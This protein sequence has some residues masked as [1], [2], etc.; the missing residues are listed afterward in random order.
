MQSVEPTPSSSVDGSRLGIGILFTVLGGV[1]W[2][3]SGACAQFLFSRYG[4]DPR[5]VVCVRLA[6]ACLVFLAVSAATDRARLAAAARSPKAMA[7]IA[8]YSLGGLTLCMVCYLNAIDASNAGTATV[9]QALNL[10]IIL[11]VTCV[12]LRR[13]PTPKEA[14]GVALA[15]AGTFLLATHGHPGTLAITPAA[16]GWG[17]AT[18]VAA[19]LY[20]LLPVR[21]LNEFGSAV[22]TGLAMLVGAVA[23]WA[24]FRPWELTPALDAAG[25]LAV[26]CIVLIGTVAAYFLFLTGVKKVGSM[27]A[28][29]FGSTEPITAGILSAVWLGTQFSPADLA[30]MGLIVAMMVL[31]A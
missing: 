30:G 23:S 1:C 26:A 15:L 20:T 29:L 17:L 4:V 28:G 10:L 22:T 19:A 24:V 13:R 2:G 3:F 14:V 7:R 12:S 11:A 27:L 18:A 8:G 9:L 25:A 5:W 21:L 6:G 31:M 16:L